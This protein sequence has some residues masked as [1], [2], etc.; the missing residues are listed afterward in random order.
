MDSRRKFMQKT[1][2]VGASMFIAPAYSF[3]D[4]SSNKN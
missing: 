1:S 2:V 4:E 3:F